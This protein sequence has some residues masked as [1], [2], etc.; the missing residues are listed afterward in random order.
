MNKTA[1]YPAEILLPDAEKGIDLTK[2]A[3][4]ACDQ[5]T[6]QPAYWD[7]TEA[8]VGENP[9]ALRLTLPEVYLEQPEAEL[10]QKIS[11]IQQ[12]MK[13]Y[14][15]QGIFRSCPDSFVYIE[16]T[17][18]DGAVRKGLL[19]ML[20]LEEY[21]YHS[22]SSSRIRATEGTV[23]ERIP[24]RVKVR[25]HAI[26]ELPH[27]MML[28]DDIQ[29][30]VIEPL[31]CQKDNLPLL[32]QF[33]LMQN[34]GSIKGYRVQGEAACIVQEALGKLAHPDAFA[35]RYH[36][37]LG[38]SV[39][40]F[41]A[42]DGN[43]SLATAKACFEELKKHL[44]EREWK[45]HPARY[46]LAEVVNLHDD[47]L[48]FEP[49]HRVVTDTEPEKLLSALKAACGALP[50]GENAKGQI[51]TAVTSSGKETFLMEK[52]TSNLAVGTLQNFLDKYLRDN[53]GKI[54]Y[55][56]GDDVAIK[57]GQAPDSISF[58]LPAM[59]KEELFPT[60]I[61]DGSLPRKTFSMGHAQDKRYYIEARK[62]T[63]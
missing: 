7:E 17:L 61:L 23:L 42:G 11:N 57:L 19:G 29:R 37:P 43:H 62:I 30:T 56:H 1:F 63:R 14:L 20:D 21:D 16:R 40:L 50:A 49:I 46:A 34:G 35:E 28:I 45:N 5:Y 3:V 39:L 2:W 27:I 18:S 41:A 44:P 52:S 31:S 9:S 25:E 33:P 22:G 51:I 13:E 36:L 6:S 8:F 24:P 12:S 53:P 4:V 38:T 60:V 48:K 15:Q 32:Y 26:L 10:N 59:G 54:D 47:S 58:L 55:I